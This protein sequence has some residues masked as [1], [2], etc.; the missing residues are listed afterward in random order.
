[1]PTK[2][3]KRY[4]EM[5]ERVKTVFDGSIIDIETIGDF[6]EV[7]RGT[8]PMGSDYL[9]R[10]RSMRITAVGVL[11]AGKLTICVA[12]GYENLDAFQK[13]ATKVM[14]DTSVPLY[15]FNKTFEEGCYFWNSE[16]RS[17][18]IDYELQQAVLERK[19]DVVKALN[20]DDYDDPFHGKGVRCKSAFASG[21]LQSI[22]K[23][24]RACLL[25]ENQILSKRGAKK[26]VTKWLD[27]DGMK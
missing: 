15:A 2:V 19:E 24:N 5:K 6:S 1:M 11:S 13:I 8:P 17:L 7:N 9:K 25:K 10:Y 18:E 22:M 12:N 4:R 14:R 21:D 27:I 26:L 20:I 23:H 3:S 16:E